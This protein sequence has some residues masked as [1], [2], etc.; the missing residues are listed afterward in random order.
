MSVLRTIA[1]KECRE[2]VFAVRGM[3]L[4][5][6][7]SLVLSAF[8]IM[9]VG[10]TELSLLDNAQ[11]V[12]M[13]AGIVLSLAVLV[14]V[15]RGSDGFAGERD[16]ETLEALL[17][18]PVSGEELALGKLAALMVSWF[19]LYLLAVPYI[20]AVGSSGQNLLSTLLYLFLVGTILMTIFGSFILS[21]S[22]RVRSFK[23]AMSAGLIL[24]LF[25]AAPVALGPSLRQSFVGRTLDWLNP[26]AIVMNM[27]DAVIIDSQTAPGQQ[28]LP[29]IV[30]SG[31][32][33]IAIWTLR[34]N[35][36]RIEL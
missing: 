22:A 32:V 30:L 33:I 13:M 8:A 17:I 25:S 23:G 4:Y 14:A 12:Y 36:R 35:S 26:F 31:Y 21:L 20:W 24:F 19:L 9:L 5:L 11:A 7:A 27:L 2:D 6:T 28:V 10:N 29:L 16:R 15:V 1:L 34:I 3:G 18:S